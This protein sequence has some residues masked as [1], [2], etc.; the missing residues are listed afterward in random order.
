MLKKILLIAARA[1]ALVGIA[2]IGTA[3]FLDNAKV[4]SLS[5]TKGA[6]E[7]YTKDLEERYAVAEPA[8]PVDLSTLLAEPV[9]PADD[10]EAEVKTKYEADLKAY[11]EQ[12]TALAEEYKKAQA[13]YEIALKQYE[14]DKKTAEYKKAQEKADMDKKKKDLE[15]AIKTKEIE[16]NVIEASVALR[17]IG[18]LF[19]ILGSL[20]I[21]ILAENMEKAAV[22]ILIGFAF[23]TIIGL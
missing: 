5:T 17:F 4:A 13:A 20:G 6:L 23:K 11:G 12:K 2:L 3:V 10:A 7:T 18:S 16:V 9:K 14:F 21:L 19:L 22:L 15:A 1:V 8:K